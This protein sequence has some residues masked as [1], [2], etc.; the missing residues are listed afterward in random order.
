MANGRSLY[1]NETGHHFYLMISIWHQLNK[2]L[3]V[4]APMYD[5]T[6]SAYRQIIADFGAPDLFFTEFVSADG[7]A[8]QAGR[9]KLLREFYFTAKEQPVIAQI[10]GSL[11]ATIEIA[12]RLAAE[13]G[14]AGVDLNMGCPDKAV[15]KQG[16]GAALIKTPALAKEL[17]LAAKRGAGD[18]PV[19]VKTRIGDKQNELEKWLPVLLEAKPAAIT[20]HFRTTKEL[21]KVEAHWD[22]APRAVEIAKGSGVLILGNGDVKTSSDALRLALETGLDGVMIGRGIFGTPWLFANLAQAKLDR[23]VEH[24]PKPLAE[25]DEPPPGHP[26]SNNL[27][28]PPAGGRCRTNPSDEVSLE[29]RLETLINHAKLFSQLYLPGDF[30][31]A[32]FGGHTKSFSVM[33]KH[34]KAY[35]NGFSG[36]AELREQL[37]SAENATTVEKIC[38]DFLQQSKVL[39]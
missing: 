5:V 39:S 22:L 8:S 20:I 14:F 11:P 10:F 23:Q 36:A 34:F 35:V 37:M 3:I 12:A 28:G 19:S 1:L 16:S 25:V 4:L 6:D 31:Q 27:C 38:Q 21:S 15:L 17:I 2:P 9:E 13:R 29:L 24:P 33:K 30:N 32:H 18:L 7:L 26:I